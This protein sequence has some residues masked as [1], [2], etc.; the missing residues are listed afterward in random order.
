MYAPRE[1][2]FRDARKTDL[3]A[4]VS[5]V[6][7]ASAID[8]R[9]ASLR[10]EIDARPAPVGPVPARPAPARSTPINDPEPVPARP[11][12]RHAGRLLDASCRALDIAGSAILLVVISPLLCAIAIAIRLDSPGPALFRQRRFGR[13]Q[14][15]FTVHKFR[16]MEDGVAEDYHREFVT[17]LIKGTGPADSA[18]P[19][20]L[21][22]GAPSTPGPRYKM[23]GDPRV[24]RCGR[25]LRR[26]SLD[27]L[28]QLWNV[29]RGE[30]SLVGPRPP[31]PYEVEQYPPHWFARFAVKP[32]VTGLW[33]VSGR[34]DVTLEEMVRLDVEYIER[35][36]PWLNIAILLRT[37]PAVLST[38]GAW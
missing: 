5:S 14:Q 35:R 26:S 27:E 29:L 1:N 7:S 18:D 15:P 20:Q 2:L 10:G 17:G 31:I 30:M 38:K 9:T 13:D 4:V 34:S 25:L 8:E 3:P 32:G 11:A 36:S 28:P 16:T 21:T 24:T 12:S 33:Q 6:V 22:P 19:A 23:T 37:V